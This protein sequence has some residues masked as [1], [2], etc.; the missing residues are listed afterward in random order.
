MNAKDALA[1]LNIIAQVDPRVL[2]AADTDRTAKAVVWGD[3]LGDVALESALRVVRD[4]LRTQAAP[5]VTPGLIREI[6]N[7]QW[8]A[9]QLTSNAPTANTAAWVVK[10]REIQAE[11]RRANAERKSTVAKHADLRARYC[12]QLGCPRHG[13][14]D[15]AGMCTFE[16]WTGF[17]PPA[18]V[19]GLRGEVPNTSP[20]RK[21]LIEIADEAEMRSE[22]VSA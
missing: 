6:V 14:G 12:S 16:A 5:S 17:V 19:P 7:R 2:P 13:K 21:W 4:I 8:E 11:A 15:A 3:L 1:V 9:P 20:R 22:M 10:G 18:T